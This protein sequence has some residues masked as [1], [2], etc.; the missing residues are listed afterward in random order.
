MI[1]DINLADRHALRGLIDDVVKVARAN[2][3]PFAVI[4]QELERAAKNIIPEDEARK[5]LAS[6]PPASPL[7]VEV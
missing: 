2:G 5:L 6:L 4:R 3:L 7:V 1:S